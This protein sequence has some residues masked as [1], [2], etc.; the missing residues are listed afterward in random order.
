LR[1]RIEQGG[2]AHIGKA[3]NTA[4]ETHNILVNNDMQRP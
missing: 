4:F 3:H 1:Q 2:L